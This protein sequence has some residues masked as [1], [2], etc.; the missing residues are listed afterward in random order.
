MTLAVAIRL[1]IGFLEKLP[2]LPGNTSF[3]E[4]AVVVMTD[5]RYSEPGGSTTTDTGAKLWH[6]GSRIAGTFAGNVELAEKG[7][8]AT[9]RRL[10]DLS[11]LSFEAIADA[12]REG[13][14]TA[15]PASRRTKPTD[16]VDALFATVTPSGIVGIIGV[17]SG[18]EFEP[19]FFKNAWIDDRQVFETFR[20]LLPVAIPPD[21]E[22]MP[23]GFSMAPDIG[24]LELRLA[25]AMTSTI[26]THNQGTVGGKIQMVAITATEYRV[27]Q[28]EGDSPAV[29]ANIT[30]ITAGP[31]DVRGLTGRDTRRKDLPPQAT[32]VGCFDL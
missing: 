28:G 8:S 4:P 18:A 13:F 22:S 7:M 1:P 24:S 32:S 30:I 15:I 2:P 27:K 5:S 6:V 23:E 17:G 11:E 26:E 31:D 10:D 12:A 19:S 21:L 20:Q 25:A 9:K 3:C 16:R 29:P 14:R